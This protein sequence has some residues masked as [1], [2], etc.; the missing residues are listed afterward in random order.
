MPKRL[1]WDRFDE[2]SDTYDDH[3][4]TSREPAKQLLRF[5]GMG[6]D[7]AVLEFGCGTGF[8]TR[9]AS[10]AVG[11]NGTV[12]ATDIATKMM[13][14]AQRNLTVSNVEFRVA[15]AV[16]PDLPAASFDVVFANCVLMGLENVSGILQ[17]W[18]TLIRGEGIVAFSSF[19]REMF[20]PFSLVP[21][22]FSVLQQYLGEM[23]NRFPETEIDSAEACSNIL[24]AIGLIDIETEELDL[25]YHYP[26]FETFW[27]EWWGSV[28]RL[29]LQVLEPGQ[30]ASLKDELRAA[31]APAFEGKGLY[32]PNITILAKGRCQG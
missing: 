7:M 25:G 17:R 5:S 9:L 20:T 11:P 28:F 8:A 29:R 1:N 3:F 12:L 16:T 4:I 18:A 23:P 24:E 30:L 14:V 6:R 26:D 19:S 32:R 2:V 15:D 21:E 13:A 22:G 10:E 31:M 27:N